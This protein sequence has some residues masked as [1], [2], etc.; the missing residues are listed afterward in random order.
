MKKIKSKTQQSKELIKLYVNA[1]INF[2]KT[3]GMTLWAKRMDSYNIEHVKLCEKIIEEMSFYKKH[4]E[5][6]CLAND[7]EF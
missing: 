1:E 2:H 4:L 7:I 5:E 6:A 3:D